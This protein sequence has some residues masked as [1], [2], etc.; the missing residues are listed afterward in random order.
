MK[1]SIFIICLL[2]TKI[3]F[4]QKGDLFNAENTLKYSAY[5]LQNQKYKE[6]IPELD[7]LCTMQPTS[8]SLQALLLK[9]Y[10]K[11]GDYKNGIIK[12][13]KYIG[14]SSMTEYISLLLL[15]ENYGNAEEILLQNSGRHS[16]K[17]KVLFLQS[18]LLRHNWDVAKT[19]ITDDEFT[20]HPNAEYYL[21]FINQNKNFHYKKPMIAAGL[22]A[23]IP[24]LGKAYSHDWKDGI[25][26]FITIGSCSYLAYK[27]F[28]KK[29]TASA[30]G[31]IYGGLAIGFYSGNIYGSYKSAKGYNNRHNQKIKHEIE[32]LII[33][34]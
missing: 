26:S 24:G 10:R 25:I 5:L 12:G 7:R 21:N 15:T 4:A 29:G 17:E 11:A 18:H 23:I 27:G 13:T 2:I 16:P 9:C 3:S 28:E 1:I 6:A 14:L 22:S 20:Y 34:D 32:A 19:I 31:W 33:A 30:L 8:D